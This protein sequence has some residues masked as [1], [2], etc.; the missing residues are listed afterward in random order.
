MACVL[1]VL[2]VAVWGSLYLNKHLRD[3]EL[4][5]RYVLRDVRIFDNSV[6]SVCVLKL[7][8][9]KGAPVIQFAIGAFV[10]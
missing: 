6:S 10:R 9:L 7:V 2:S 5:A 1:Q 8:S 3:L 4:A